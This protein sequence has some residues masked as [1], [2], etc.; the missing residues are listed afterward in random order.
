V[1]RVEYQRI[2]KGNSI[3][4]SFNSLD[5]HSTYR[6]VSLSGSSGTASNTDGTYSF[7]NLNFPFSGKITFK[8]E[9]KITVNIDDKTD[10]QQITL[11]DCFLDFELLEKGSWEI[12]IF[13]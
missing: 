2:G 12:I 9:S 10:N 11:Q 3:N 13:Y 1:V 8:T 6:D 5:Q 4:V 7:S